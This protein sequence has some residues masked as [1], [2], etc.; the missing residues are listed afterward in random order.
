[1]KAN[2]SNN[3]LNKDLSNLLEGCPPDKL[4]LIYDIAKVIIN[5]K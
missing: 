4:K 5:E 3:Y 2:D 1:M